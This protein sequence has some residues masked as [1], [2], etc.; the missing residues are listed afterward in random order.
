[1][2]FIGVSLGSQRAADS[3]GASVL[4]LRSL[5][6]GFCSSLYR[7]ANAFPRLNRCVAGVILGIGRP[8]PFSSYSLLASGSRDKFG[9][10]VWPAVR[11]REAS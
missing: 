1:M 5:V 4:G 10:D 9:E 6:A 8:H 2:N 11:A 7:Y 3:D